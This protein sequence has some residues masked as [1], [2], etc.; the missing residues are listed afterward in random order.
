MLSPPP[1]GSFLGFTN[2]IILH[3]FGPYFGMPEASPFVM[4]TM[5]Q[6][7]LAGREYEHRASGVAGAPAGKVERE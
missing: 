5:I 2:V 6:L 3:G 1:P 4:K 7:A